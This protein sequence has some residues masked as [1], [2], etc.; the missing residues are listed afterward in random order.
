[1]LWTVYGLSIRFVNVSKTFS[2]MV[3]FGSHTSHFSL[4]AI[5]LAQENGLDLIF[6]PRCSYKLHCFNVAIFGSLYCCFAQCNAQLIL[7][8]SSLVMTGRNLWK[9]ISIWFYYVIYK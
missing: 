7:I 2:F 8:K 1:M 6:P 3:F 9:S 4:D 5:D